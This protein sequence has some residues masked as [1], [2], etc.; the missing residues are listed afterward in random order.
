MKI[1]K[2]SGVNYMTDI[3]SDL[4]SFDVV[5]IDEL[6]MLHEK[7]VKIFPRKRRMVNGRAGST[8][9]KGDIHYPQTYDAMVKLRG[10]YLYLELPHK[11][12]DDYL[13]GWTHD[14]CTI[15]TDNEKRVKCDCYKCVNIK[16]HI[17]WK[18][19]KQKVLDGIEWRVSEKTVCSYGTFKTFKQYG[20]A[21]PIYNYSSQWPILGTHRIAYCSVLKSDIPFFFRIFDDDNENVYRGAYPY[22]KD[23][24]YCHMKIMKNEKKVS[25][26]LS[27]YFRNFDE[28][29]D[30]KIG[31]ISYK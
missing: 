11:F 16:H 22:F 2:H 29:R 25:F 5:G 9:V 3:F 21:K 31:E 15:D 27:S 12:F 6:L 8:L 4:K 10:E 26:Y 30:E 23:K 13:I 7:L 14:I 18:S 24:K 19:V 17:L 28:D 20:I 1:Y